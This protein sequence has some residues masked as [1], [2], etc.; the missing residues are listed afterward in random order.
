[1]SPLHLFDVYGALADVAFAD[2]V[3]DSIGD[4]MMKSVYEPPRRRKHAAIMTRSDR[5]GCA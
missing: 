2:V 1:M 3:P 5:G 4:V